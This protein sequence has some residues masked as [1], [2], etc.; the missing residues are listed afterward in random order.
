MIEITGVAK[1][2]GALRAL[3]GVD[4][5]VR[6]GELFGLIG[7]NGAG[8]STLFQLML[9]LLSADEGRVQVD[10]EC[11][12]GPRF[13]AVK[14]RLGYLPEN[15]VLYDNLSGLETLRF[16]ARLKGADVAGC[17]P[18]LE[19]V[20]L[21]SA[22]ERKVREYSKGMK[23][24]LGFAQA[25]LGDPALL[26]LD[27][28]TNGLDPEGIREFYRTLKTRQEAGT[29]IVITS[30][31]LAEIQQRVDRLAILQAGRIRAAGS[32]SALRGEANLPLSI[33]VIAL[34][35][36]THAIAEALR[37]APFGELTTRGR[38]VVVECPR[39]AKMTAIAALAPLSG[40]IADLQIHEPSLEDVFLGCTEMNV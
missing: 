27:E 32:V 20:G 34:S 18:L 4:L 25:L 39:E 6:K 9:G 19:Q 11:A 7:R 22:A 5:T 13:R 31:I 36:D 16:F 8:K 35:D 23:Q 17:M 1:A 14:R 37:R 29:T 26:F 30:H 38:H 10:G 2:F 40:R 24:R 3:D 33:E 15:V 28:P 21:A 12:G